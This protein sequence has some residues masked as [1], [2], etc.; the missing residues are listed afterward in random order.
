M[1]QAEEST[2]LEDIL[3]TFDELKDA[4]KKHEGNWEEVQQYVAPVVLSFAL[5]DG[6]YKIPERPRRYT[7]R[8]THYLQSLVSGISGY[9]ITPSISWLKLTLEQ[10]ELLEYY[11][12]KDWLE[13]VERVLYTEFNSSNL[14]AQVPQLIKYAA[15]YGHGVMLIDENIALNKIRFSAINITEIFTDV[16][17]FDEIN[18]IYRYF[19]MTI[20]QAADFFGLEN[21]HEKIQEDFEDKKKWK[22]FIKIIHAVYRRTDN[23]DEKKDNKNMAFA[24]IYIDETNKHIIQESGYQENP[25]AIFVWDRIQGTGYGFSPAFYALDD[26]KLLNKTEEARIKIAQLSAEPPMNVPRVMLGQENVVPKGYN[27]YDTPNEIMTPIQTGANF[28]ISL[29]VTKSIEERIRD[30]F[31]VDFFLSLLNDQRMQQMTATEVMELQGEKAAVL[32]DLV[33][34]LSGALMSI[35]KRS[36]NILLKQDKLPMPPSALAGSGGDFKI[37]FM[38]PLAQAQKRHHESQNIGQGIQL[39]GTLSQINPNV[40]DVVDFDQLLKTGLE[41][42]GIPQNAIRETED[43]AK[44]RLQRQQQ[45]QAMQQQAMQQQQQQTLVSNMDKLNQPLNK[46]TALD[47]MGQAMAGSQ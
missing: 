21:L 22:N 38:G 28:P 13:S 16:D 47:M 10:Q 18:T 11:G 26:I 8:P 9:S 32:S 15:T 4:R 2:L 24:S 42:A 45:Q 40:M 31:H 20:K 3:Y 17:E 29:E 5:D 37:N 30:W 39:I 23:D 25:Y 1:A 14:Y 44:I 6:E 27:Y 34:N 36:F 33:V 46:G 43:V 35:V 7:S 19:S 12:V 41:S